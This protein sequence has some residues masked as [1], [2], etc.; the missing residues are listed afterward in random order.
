MPRT[1]IAAQT[2][3]GA[4]PTLPISPD[5]R[6]VAFVGANV[7]DGNDTALVAG[8]TLVLVTN[9]DTVAH[10][11]S[12]TSAPDTLNRKGDITAYSVGAGNI[13]LFG[14]FTT[15][16]WAVGG[17]LQIN[18]DNVNIEIAVITLP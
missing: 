4:Y 13:A 11:V 12:F 17:R 16:G 9:V 8:K 15:V 2:T 6:D 18:G 5:A 10:T 14:P 1:N 7:A 3:P